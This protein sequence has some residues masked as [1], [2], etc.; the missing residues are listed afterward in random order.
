ML[1]LKLN[2]HE[3]VV[4]ATPAGDVTLQLL[5]NHR[6]GIDAPRAWPVKRID[7]EDVNN[8]TDRAGSA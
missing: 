3:R 4:I 5:D 7:I 1:V 8:G 6:V 2:A